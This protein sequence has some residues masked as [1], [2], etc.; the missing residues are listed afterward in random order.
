MDMNIAISGFSD[1]PEVKK[2][3][4]KNFNISETVDN[5]KFLLIKNDIDFVSYKSSKIKQAL[6]KNLPII[7]FEKI[8]DMDFI[9]HL[10]NLNLK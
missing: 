2:L 8:K 10:K 6:T 3:I 9:K 4:E 7:Y 1:T 5:V